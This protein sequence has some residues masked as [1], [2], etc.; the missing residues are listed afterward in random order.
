MKTKADFTFGFANSMFQSSGTV[1]GA[2]NWTEAAQK[3]TVPEVVLPIIHWDNFE[4]D[5][6][7]MKAVGMDSYRVSIEWSHIE[8]QKNQ[9]DLQVLKRYMDLVD[10]CIQRNITPMLTLFHFNEPLWFTHLGG[11]EQEENIQHY[12]AFCKYVFQFLS[13]KVTLWCT[14]NE[15]AVLAFSGYLLGQFPPHKHHLKLT[16]TVLNNLMKAHVQVYYELKALKYGKRAMVGIVHNVLRFK[17]RHGDAITSKLTNELTTITDDLVMRFFKTGLFEYDSTL[18]GVHIHY[19]DSRACKAND[20][21]GLNFY[22]N[23]VIGFNLKNG[24]GATCYS[25]QEMGDMYLPLDPTGFSEAIDEVA[26]LEIPIYITETGIADR[27][28]IIRQHFLMQYF[29]VIKLKLE[30]HIKIKGCFFW[31]F[32]DNYEWNEGGPTGENARLFGFYDKNNQPRES[33]KLLKQIIRNF[34]SFLKSRRAA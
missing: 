17:S 19:E 27:T 1:C 34:S 21:F 6:D 7:L 22:A 33:V 4:A 5:L 24:F 12:V 32:R 18:W 3:G 26:Q 16:L 29:E 20:F 2:S 11:F 25:N 14:I 10:A 23:P 8:P 30:Q 15:P 13:P 9:Y 28:D 31:V